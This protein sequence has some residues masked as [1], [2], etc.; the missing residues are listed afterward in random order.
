MG[1]VN[2]FS[3]RSC[4]DGATLMRVI[5][6]HI[7]E[8]W[9][10]SFEKQF[11]LHAHKAPFAK[12]DL[13]KSRNYRWDPKKSVWHKTLFEKNL[14]AEEMYLEQNVYEGKPQHELREH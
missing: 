5:D 7:E 14:K 6:G 4:F 2:A 8:L 3:H 9:R 10:N 13:L 1:F 12:K 11:T